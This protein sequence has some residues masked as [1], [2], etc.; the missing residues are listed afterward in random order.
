MA[1]PMT[2]AVP[3]RPFVRR[4][5][6]KAARRS[7]RWIV[8]LLSRPP[9]LRWIA[10]TLVVGA[11]VVWDVSA[12]TTESFPFAAERIESGSRITDDMIDWRDIPS[13]S[14]WMPVLDDPRAAVDIE[15]GD[16]I[17]RSVTEGALVVPTDWWSVPIELPPGVPDGSPVRLLL[18][19]GRA[20]DGLVTAP[21]PDEGFGASI[22]SVAVASEDLEEVASA[23]AAGLVLVLIAPRG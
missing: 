19:T 13:G 20:V 5:P 14:L 17:T 21:A 1:T 11:A 7:V 10:V 12:R 22:G 18:P 6:S 4:T 3:A 9:Y 2:Q 16:P 15:V 8:L 23:S